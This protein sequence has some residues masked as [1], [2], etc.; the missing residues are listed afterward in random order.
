MIEQTFVIGIGH[1]ARAG[2]NWVAD[3]IHAQYPRITKIYSFADALR[4][5]A[6]ADYGMTSKDP[7][8][9]QALGL[10][11]REGGI[12]PDLVIERLKAAPTNNYDFADFLEG[13]MGVSAYNRPANLDVW[14]KIIAGKI[15]EDSPEFALIS[16]VRFPNEVKVCDATIRVR[17]W[18][19]EENAEGQWE[20]RPY[21]A[22]DRPADHPSETALD[23]DRFWAHTIDANS[24]DVDYLSLKAI[25]TFKTIVTAAISSGQVGVPS[26]S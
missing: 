22:D 2:K 8:L 26:S 14:V 16:D 13:L 21:V 10:W 3:T 11:Y 15:L 1:R 9:L 12:A 5:V 25:E 23:G 19:K 7:A 18:N 4:A 20:M 6:R 17:R 24:G